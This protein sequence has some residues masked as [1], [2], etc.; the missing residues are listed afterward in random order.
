[1]LVPGTDISSM[2]FKINN[3]HAEN[4]LHIRE[5]TGMALLISHQYTSKLTITAIGHAGNIYSIRLS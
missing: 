5:N 3:D 4:I 2:H 1:M